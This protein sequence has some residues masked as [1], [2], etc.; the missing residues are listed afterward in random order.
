MSKDL[1]DPNDPLASTAKL[2]DDAMEVLEEIRD[3]LADQEGELPLVRGTDP[4]LLRAS[5]E[6]VTAVLEAIKDKI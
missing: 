3:Y 2:V 4:E 1:T 6:Y 5:L